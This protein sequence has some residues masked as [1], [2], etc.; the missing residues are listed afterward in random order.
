MRA[1]PKR[2]FIKKKDTGLPVRKKVCRFCLDKNKVIN[3]KEVKAL[4]YFIKERGKIFPRRISGNCAKHQRRLKRAL[5]Q[6]R[7]MSL[8]PYVRI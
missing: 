6:A 7:F 8:L 3:Y 4:E 2:A 1:K 5:R